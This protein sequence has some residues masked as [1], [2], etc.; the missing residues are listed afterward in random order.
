MIF[1]HSARNLEAFALISECVFFSLSDF[2]ATVYLWWI[3][4]LVIRQK[5]LNWMEFNFKG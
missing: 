2:G 3:L 1:P 5:R 4:E